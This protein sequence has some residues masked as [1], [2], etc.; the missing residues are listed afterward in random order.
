MNSEKDLRN[1]RNLVS[2]SNRHTFNCASPTCT[3]IILESPPSRGGAKVAAS[4]ISTLHQVAGSTRIIEIVSESPDCSDSGE[5]T[6]CTDHAGNTINYIVSASCEDGARRHYTRFLR[7]VRMVPGDT[8]K[9]VV[10]GSCEDGADDAGHTTNYVV[11]D[12]MAF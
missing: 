1:R 7:A 2:T 9:Y 11:S 10:S 12:M 4:A 3:K 6:D 5:D 8:T